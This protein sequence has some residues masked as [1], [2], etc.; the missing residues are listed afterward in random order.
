[1]V[2]MIFDAFFVGLDAN[3]ATIA[4]RA[5]GVGEELD[6]HQQVVQHDRL[7]HVELEVALRTRKRNSVVVSKYLNCD[8]R[9][10]LALSR[11]DRARHDGGAGFVFRN[12]DFA[13]PGSRAA[14]VP[15]NVIP[16]LHQ[17]AGKRAKGSAHGHHTVVCRKRREFVWS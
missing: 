9:E 17:R 8:H 2:E 1:M 7:V 16:D 4:E 6:R 3:G 11:I 5:A 13:D 15:S 12:I 10:S 14:G